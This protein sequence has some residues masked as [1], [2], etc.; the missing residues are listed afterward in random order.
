MNLQF[1]YR[2]FSKVHSWAQTSL[3]H[4]LY[5]VLSC[6]ISSL[7]LYEEIHVL[8]NNMCFMFFHVHKLKR[9]KNI[10]DLPG[11]I[12]DAL[13][14]LKLSVVNRKDLLVL[15]L[16]TDVTSKDCQNNSYTTY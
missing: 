4:V 8:C 6:L 10:P 3:C 1:R 16:H 15:N 9:K 2:Q 7:V 11:H 5:N 12:L 14:V 13:K